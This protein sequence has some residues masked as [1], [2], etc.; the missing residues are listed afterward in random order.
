[1]HHESMTDGSSP[2]VLQA[3]FWGWLT[4]VVTG[5]VLVAMLVVCLRG[6]RP[7]DR[8]AI[9]RALAELVSSCRRKKGG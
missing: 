4:A 6:T 8:P 2:L 1:M 3:A 7:K 9:I 5:V